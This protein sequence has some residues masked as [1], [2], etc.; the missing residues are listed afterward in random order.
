MRFLEPSHVYI[1]VLRACLFKN[2][3]IALMAASVKGAA[4][5]VS[6]RQIDFS[7]QDSNSEKLSRRLFSSLPVRLT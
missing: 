7:S 4:F 2:S 5:F 3:G 6:D 1:G